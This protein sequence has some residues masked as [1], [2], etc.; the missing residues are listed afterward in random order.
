MDALH[1]QVSLL[2][3]GQSWKLGERG[4]F[5]G[6]DETSKAF[7]IYLPTQRK[8]VVRREVRFEE[9]RA[10]RRS[11]DSEIE[12]QQTTPHV[13]TSQ[14]S[15]SQGIGSQVSGVTGSH[16][17]GSLVSRT[18]STGNSGTRT[19]SRITGSQVTPSCDSS[20]L[21]IG[22]NSLGTG[23][24]V[25]ATSSGR[26]VFDEDVEE[27]LRQDAS[28]KK[29][30]PSTLKELMKEAEKSVGPPRREVRERKVP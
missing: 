24:Q 8:V 14:S 2:R 5:V 3:R 16:V 19:G 22:S 21:G 12:E 4:I 17:R 25:V 18:Q 26:Q 11:R 1:T 10:F 6:Y 27:S 15:A 7:R 28:S 20:S 9:E 30:K 13:T 23:S 29:R